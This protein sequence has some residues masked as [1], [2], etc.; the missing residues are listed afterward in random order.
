MFL[1]K[2]TT[3]RTYRFEQYEDLNSMK[4]GRYVNVYVISIPITS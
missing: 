4:S 1:P 3:N 2:G